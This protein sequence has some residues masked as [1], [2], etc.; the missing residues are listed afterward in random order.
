MKKS[1]KFCET[2]VMNVLHIATW[3]PTPA[4]PNAVPFIKAHF[5]AVRQFGNHRLLHIEVVPDGSLRLDWKFGAADSSKVRLTGIRGPTRLRELLTFLLLLLARL[6][7]G[8]SKWDVVIVHVAWPTLR[9]PRAFRALFGQKVILIEHW[10][11]YSRDFY[12]DPGSSAHV[13]MR[14]MLLP[15]IPIIAVSDGLAKDIRSFARRDDLDLRIVPNV[16]DARFHFEG[17]SAPPTILMAANWNDFRKPFFVLEAMADLLLVHPDLQLKIAGDGRKLDAMKAFVDGSAWSES[18]TFL[19]SVSR[20]RVAEEM[21]RATLFAHPTTHET[22]S[23]VTAEAM[24]CGVPVVVSN[25]GAVP[26]LVVSGVNG[27]LVENDA[28]A[29]R[30]ALVMAI[31]PN[32]FWDREGV[33]SQATNQFSPDNV[34]ERIAAILSEIAAQ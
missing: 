23:V 28:A 15:D 26:E 18:V 24:C 21:R 29:W 3:Y 11:A 2:F 34:G 19:G 10:S 6:R 16:V 13:R 1:K 30:E 12:L 20:D 4:N 7:L 9:F 14:K 32:K 27:Y 8:L 22:F 5:D 33:A 17:P 25:V 31:N